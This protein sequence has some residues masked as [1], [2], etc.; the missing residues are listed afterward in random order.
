MTASVPAV[1]ALAAAALVPA[2]LGG[3]ERLAA[4]SSELIDPVWTERDPASD[5]VVDHSAL[6]AFLAE[7]RRDGSPARIDYG[8]VTQADAATLDGYIGDLGAVDP[9][10][11]A[12]DEQLAYWLN[13]YN[14][15]TLALVLDHYPVDSIRDIGSG[16]FEDGPWD[17]EVV[18][19]LGRPLTLNEIEHGIV[20]PVYGEPRIHYAVNCAAVDCPGIA[21]TAWRGA[22]LDARLAAAERAFVND[23]RGVRVEDGELVLNKIWLWFREDF[24]ATEAG[25]LDRLRE[26][27]EG[28]TAT[29]LEGREAPD[30]YA[31]DWSLNDVR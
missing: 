13:L 2:V 8:A 14:A 28:R 3:L 6:D 11:L 24:A 10:T 22:G 23:P 5:R 25:L 20:R 7:Y 26:V 12:A 21:P 15:A 30:G 16:L 29:A 31:Y 4:P 18:E 9:R 19:V 27:A 1:L 17:R